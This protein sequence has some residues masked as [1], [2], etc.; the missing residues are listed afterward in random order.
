M[1]DLVGWKLGGEA[2]PA[3]EPSEFKS[4]SF[5]AK[6]VADLIDHPGKVWIIM[7]H[8]E[9]CV[10]TYDGQMYCWKIP[11]VQMGDCPPKSKDDILH[12]ADAN[13]EMEA[14]TYSLDGKLGMI[15]LKELKAYIKGKHDG[16]N[17]LVPRYFTV[18]MFAGG[19]K[20]KEG[21]WLGESSMWQFELMCDIF[22][23]C[24]NMPWIS[25]TQTSPRRQPM[26]SWRSRRSNGKNSNMDCVNRSI[27]AKTTSGVHQRHC[28]LPMGTK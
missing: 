19:G 1:L 4:F 22:D 9:C 20:G 15:T 24:F 14:G 21:W 16:S 26:T 12:I 18:R 7:C 6:E 8:D 5:L 17:P 3:L 23:L 25:D 10:H 2:R 28:S 27:V 13:G 11:G